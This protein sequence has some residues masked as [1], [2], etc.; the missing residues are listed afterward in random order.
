M[1][2]KAKLVDLLQRAREEERTFFVS[3]SDDERSAAGTPE[4]WLLKMSRPI[5]QSGRHVW[6]KGL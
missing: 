5:W 1:E 2:T 6:G 3:L 4:H